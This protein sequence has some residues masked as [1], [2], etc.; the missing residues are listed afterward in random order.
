MSVEY[1]SIKNRTTIELTEKKSRFIADAGTIQNEDDA[2]VFIGE[3]KAHY[4]EASHHT[5]AYVLG[6]NVPTARYSD[7]GEPHGTAGLPILGVIQGNKLTNTIVVVTRYF[8]GTKLGTG[9]LVRAYSKS[10]SDCLTTAGITRHIPG[11]ITK[12]STDYHNLGKIKNYLEK[13]SYHI[14]NEEYA[15]HVI[16]MTLVPIDESEVLKTK[17]TD[18]TNATAEIK[19]VGER[20]IEAE[21]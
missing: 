2:R 18:L 8:G 1:K 9:G 6:E 16:I 21:G 4:R 12:I 7:D 13:H 3:I 10:T 15:T 14:I 19:I 17:L 11:Y 5:Y 20:Y